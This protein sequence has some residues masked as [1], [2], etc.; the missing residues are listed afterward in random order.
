MRCS[1]PLQSKETRNNFFKTHLLKMNF[2]SQFNGAEGLEKR[3][4]RKLPKYLK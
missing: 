4:R 1:R 2:T 3:K